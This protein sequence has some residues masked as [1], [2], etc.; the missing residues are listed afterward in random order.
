[1]GSKNWLGSWGQP[2]N[3]FGKKNDPGKTDKET[4]IVIVPL[5]FSSPAVGEN[6]LFC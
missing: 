4:E 1:M 3:V 5:K 2:I 6:D